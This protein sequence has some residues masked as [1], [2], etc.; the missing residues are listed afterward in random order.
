[1]SEINETCL[2]T[3]TKSDGYGAEWKTAC[4]EDIYCETPD[5]VGI[6]FPPLPNEDGKFC[7]FCGKEIKIKE[8]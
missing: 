8:K 2:Y 4:G 6:C 7:H 3:K 1:M 5:D